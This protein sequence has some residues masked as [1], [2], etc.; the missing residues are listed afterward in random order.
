MDGIGLQNA[1]RVAYEA[2]TNFVT[3]EATYQT[4]RQAWI[5]AAN[6][7]NPAYAASVANAWDAVGVNDEIAYPAF[8]TSDESFENDVSI[9]NG[10]TTSGSGNWTLTSS[11]GAIGAK[12]LQSPALANSESASVTYSAATDTGY[13]SFFARTSSEKGYDELKLYVDGSLK[14]SWSGENAWMP[15][16]ASVGN[17]PHEFTWTY[18]KDNTL[19]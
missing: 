3:S 19:S 15:V 14:N 10:W 6:A 17:G 12:S 7:V 16:T 2:N 18:A 8:V 4:V 1:A 9:P 5:D 13:L 11:T